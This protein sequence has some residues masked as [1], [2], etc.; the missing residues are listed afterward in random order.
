VFYVCPSIWVTRLRG[1]AGRP[2]QTCFNKRVERQAKEFVLGREI[3]SHVTF[4]HLGFQNPSPHQQNCLDTDCFFLDAFYLRTMNVWVCALVRRQK[5][6]S[7]NP[8]HRQNIVIRRVALTGSTL[9]QRRACGKSQMVSANECLYAHGL[10]M[11]KRS[12]DSV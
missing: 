1:S 8:L 5:K 7:A 4:G 6:L 9:A 11:H 12:Q 3:L 10:M 2:T